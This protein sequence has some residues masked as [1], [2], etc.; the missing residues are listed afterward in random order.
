MFKKTVL[1]GKYNG[2]KVCVVACVH[3]DEPIGFRVIEQLKRL[4]IEKGSLTLILA[5]PRALNLKKRYVESDLNRSFNGKSSTLEEKLARKLKHELYKSDLVLDV[6]ATNS[7][8]KEL[9]ITTSLR[10]SHLHLL[11]YTPIDKIMYAPRRV[12]GGNE[13][14]SNA[15]IAIALE[16][17]PNKKGTNYR[18]PLKHIKNILSAF[19]LLEGKPKI[20]AKKEIYTVSGSYNVP[21]SFTPLKNLREFKAIRKGQPIGHLEMKKV[22]AKYSFFPIFLGR[23]RYKNTLALAAREKVNIRID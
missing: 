12:F 2:P 14:I 19:G 10:R 7:N 4:T 22:T 20:S 5:H 3:G 11:K 6:H 17:G 15:K 8:F 21:E 23:G 9:A 13:L 1:R 18:Y 16:Y